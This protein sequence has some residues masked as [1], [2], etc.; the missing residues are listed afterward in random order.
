MAIVTP[1][2]VEILTHTPKVAVLNGDF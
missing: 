2:G 1:A